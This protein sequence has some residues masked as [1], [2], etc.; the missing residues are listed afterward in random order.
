MLVQII[1]KKNSIDKNAIKLGTGN[2]N[3][4]KYKIESICENILYTRES[5]GY[6]SRLYY[7]V[8]L[9]NYLE[10]KNI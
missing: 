2:N 7:L 6:L 5:M 10:E 9:K 4:K 8:F 1:I 3:S